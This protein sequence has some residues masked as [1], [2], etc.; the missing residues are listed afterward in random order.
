MASR[1]LSA[2]IPCLASM[3]LWAMEPWMS[4]EASRLSKSME[5]LMASMS[6]LGEDENR[7]PHM[8][9]APG[10]LASSDTVLHP[11]KRVG[12]AFATVFPPRP[13]RIAALPSPLGSLRNVCQFKTSCWTRQLLCDLHSYWRNKKRSERCKG[14]AMKRLPKFLLSAAMVATMATSF[15]AVMAA[16][17][18]DT[19]VQAW[20]IDDIISLDPGRGV[21]DQRLRDHRQHL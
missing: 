7:P 14:M 4:W 18:A 1:S 11:I 13:I 8:V 15:S 10:F 20:Q 5:A 16:T 19:L 3:V 12:R 17:P 2:M 21:R 6:A 9:L